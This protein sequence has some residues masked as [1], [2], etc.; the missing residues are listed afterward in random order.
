MTIILSAANAAQIIQFSDRRLSANG[1]VIEEGS[2]KATVFTCGNARFAV[3]FT[4]LAKCRGFEFQPWL[5]EAL[6]RCA[7]PDFGAIETTS[8][9]CVEITKL[10]STHPHIHGLPASSKRLTVMLSGYIYEGVRPFVCNILITNFQDFLSGI[11]HLEARPEFWVVEEIENDEADEPVTLIQRV[12][13][14]PAMT[15]DDEQILRKLLLRGVSV[16]SLV[17]TGVS[18]VRRMSG[19]TAS[20]NSIGTEISVVIVPSDPDQPVET[21]IRISTGSDRM[22]LVD[23]VEARA[24]PQPTIMVRDIRIQVQKP[25]AGAPAFQPKIGRNVRCWCSSGKKF[26]HCHGR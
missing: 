23:T 25:T 17:D 18:L 22:L 4:G 16:N 1:K 7:P 13:A 14:W 3:G 10:F 8:R 12:G 20:A 9:L 21:R 24:G 2:N 26:K 11:D 19:R 6:Y 5:V 15:D